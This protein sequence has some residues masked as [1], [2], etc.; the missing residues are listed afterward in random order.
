MDCKL[1][2]T[3]INESDKNRKAVRKSSENPD[4]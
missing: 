2:E 3:R 4:W 1:N